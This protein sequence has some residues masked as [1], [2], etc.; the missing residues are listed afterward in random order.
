MVDIYVSSVMRAFAH[1]LYRG[2]NEMGLFDRKTSKRRRRLMG[3]A[4]LILSGVVLSGCGTSSESTAKISGPQNSSVSIGELEKEIS[5]TMPVIAIQTKSNAKD[6]LKFIDEPVSKYVAESIASWTPGYTMPPAP[7]YEDCLITVIEGSSK[8]TLENADA[9]VKV[10]G[11]WTTEYPKKSLRLK[12]NKKQNLLGLNEGREFKNWVLLAS[13]KDGSMLRDKTAF[14][15]SDALLSEDGLYCSDCELVSVVVNGEYRGI[16]LLAEYQQ[17]GEGRVAGASPKK[18]YTGTDIGYLI[19]LDGYYG[20]EDRLHRFTIN[21]SDNA[22]L[23]PYDGA[24]GSGRTINYLPKD[25]N[26]PKDTIGFTIKSDI[27][28]QSQTDFIAGFVENVYN[29]MYRAAYDGQAYVFNE[30][31]SGISLSDSIT[32][33]EAVERVVD[34]NSLADMYL[35]SELTCDADIYYSSFYMSVDFSADGNRKLTFQAPWDYD[36]SMGLKNRCIDGTG[37][38]AGNIVPDVN[39]GTDYGWNFDTINPWLAVLTYQDWFMDIV[40]TK[41]Q[42]AYASGLFEDTL[43]MISNDSAHLKDEFKR[44]Y[45]KWNNLKDKSIFYGELSTRQRN[46]IVQLDAADWLREWLTKRIDFLNGAYGK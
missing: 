44:N 42:K 13:Y 19:E 39:G 41:W 17:L 38:Y 26:D 15:I 32:P 5:G 31:Y 12:F 8:V 35:I 20:T 46:C 3:A 40:R 14:R 27:Y 23:I 43:A 33:R 16:Y 37:Y 10:R 4:V 9:Q 30:D 2:R 11:N 25:K 34:V 7:Y 18:D 22:P 21:Y 24:D 28:A 6:V 36:S 29:I 1:I 45:D